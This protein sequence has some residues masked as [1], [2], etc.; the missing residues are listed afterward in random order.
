MIDAARIE[1]VSAKDG[2]SLLVR[3]WAGRRAASRGRRWSSCTASRSTPGGTS[4]SA[5]SSPP[6]ASIRTPPTS[7]GSAGPAAH[8]HR[9]SA[10]RSCTTTSRS[11][12]LRF[13]RSRPAGPLVLYGHSLGGLIALGYVLD[14]R[15]R[16][17]LLVLSAPAIG[18][19]IPL[20][21]RAARRARCGASRPG[22]LLSNRLD[23]NDL[24]SDANVRAKYLSD[25]LNQHK[26]T[27]RFAHA[28]FGEQRRV[29]ASARP[30]VDPDIRRARRRGSPR[31]DRHQ[32]GAGGPG[33]R[34][35]PGLPGGAPRAAQRAGGSGR[36]QGHRGLD[37]RAGEPDARAGEQLRGRW[38]RRTRIRAAAGAAARSRR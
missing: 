14:G 35:A 8:G 30:A 10:G 31:P 36:G 26:S 12:W 38:V 2:T 7:G 29:A 9:S 3:H 23:T 11:A 16:P 1:H 25:P 19:R 37:P 18:A 22:L 33:G 34:H 17:D 20:W 21:Q 32:R 15:A 4:T 24:S 28:A 6:R 27:V 13:D 5:R